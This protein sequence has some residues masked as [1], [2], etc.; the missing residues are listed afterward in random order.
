MKKILVFLMAIYS[1]G[2]FADDQLIPYKIIKEDRVGG[3]KL[4]LDVEVSVAEGRLPNEKELGELSMYLATFSGKYDR[5]FVVYYLPGMIL[6]AG[7]FATAHHNPDMNVV[8]MKEML[9]EY[10]K[11]YYL[12]PEIREQFPDYEPR[13]Q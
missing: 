2:V 13:I 4:S 9:L 7:G 1:V 8:M 10:P 3:F 6:D 11:Y 12:I 5:V